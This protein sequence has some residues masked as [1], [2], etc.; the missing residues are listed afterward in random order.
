M[1][2]PRLGLHGVSVGLLALGATP[3]FADTDAGR[4]VFIPQVADEIAAGAPRSRIEQDGGGLEAQVLQ[5]GD[6][7]LSEIHQ[8][9]GDHSADVVQSGEHKFSL[10]EQRGD[11][12]IAS[13]LQLSATPSISVIRQNGSGHVAIV[14][15]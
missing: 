7:L 1:V 12:H 4:L 10:V 3:A 6:G 5:G 8:S 2:P 9:G 14:R 15:Q 13:V 11:G